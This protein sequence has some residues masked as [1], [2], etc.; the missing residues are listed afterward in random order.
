[1]SA[2]ALISIRPQ[3]GAEHGAARNRTWQ[4]AFDREKPLK[5]DPLTGWAGGGGDARADQV[6]LTFPTKEDA[7]AYCERQGLKFE[8]VPEPPRRLQ[9]QSYADNFK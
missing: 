2:T 7:I 1:M 3:I 4:V 8:V 6:R 5:P 9:L